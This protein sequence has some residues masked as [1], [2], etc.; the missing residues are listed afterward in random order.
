MGY[1]LWTKVGW[2]VSHM[3]ALAAYGAALCPSPLVN[4]RLTFPALFLTFSL[5]CVLVHRLQT[6]T[7]DNSAKGTFVTVEAHSF[8]SGHEGLSCLAL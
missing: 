4:S 1:Y 2:V 3:A 5:P 6:C 8:L 7:A